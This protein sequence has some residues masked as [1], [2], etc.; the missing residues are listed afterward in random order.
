MRLKLALIVL[1]LSILGIGIF[2]AADASGGAPPDSRLVNQL[3]RWCAP[4]QCTT[5]E[6]FQLV[7]DNGLVNPRGVNFTPR[8]GVCS[9]FRIPRNKVQYDIWTGNKVLSGTAAYVGQICVGSFRF[10]DTP[11]GKTPTPTPTLG[12]THT[13]TPTP[14]P[15]TP[16]CP[17]GQDKA[18]LVAT[19]IGGNAADWEFQEQGHWDMLAHS[20]VSLKAPSTGELHVPHDNPRSVSSGKSALGSSAKFLCKAS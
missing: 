10:L 1:L 5:E 13:P 20:R 16:F 18:A 4:R 6:F 15:V 7:E 9:T 11:R 14:T 3:K 12:P 2:A 17:N 8:D 19:R